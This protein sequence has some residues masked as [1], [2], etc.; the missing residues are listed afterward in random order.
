MRLVAVLAAAAA[1]AGC[2]APPQMPAPYSAAQDM[3]CQM[4]ARAATAGV[5]SGFAAGFEQGGLARQCRQ[6]ATLENMEALG[7]RLGFRLREDT[8]LNGEQRATVAGVAEACGAPEA[9][10]LTQMQAA[11]PAAWLRGQQAGRQA[12]EGECAYARM[13]AA[14]MARQ[15]VGPR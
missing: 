14:I 1:L 7:Q 2:Q 13:G 12:S 9:A 5:V 4:N 11:S 6:V 15:Q 10:S 3:R 8:P